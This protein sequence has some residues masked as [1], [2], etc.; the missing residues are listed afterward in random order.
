MSKILSS[1][2]NFAFHFIIFIEVNYIL[3]KFFV[4][5][6]LLF[7]VSEASAIPS[8]YDLRDYGRI[9]SVKHQGIPGPCWA[10]AA[11][12][13]CES[14]YLTQNLNTDGKIPDL[15]EM[16][17]AF[18][19]YKNPKTETTFTSPK[20]GTLSLEGNTFMPV[21][22][23]SRLAGPVDDK[24]LRYST[25]LSYSEIKNLAKKLPESF[26][27]SMRLRDAY[28]LSGIN[29]PNE[30]DRKN[31]I[32]NHGAIAVTMY[33]DPNKYRTKGKYYTY[34]NNEHGKETNHLVTIAGWDDNFSRENFEPKPS[35][36]GAWLIKNS[37]GTSRGTNDGYFWLSYDQ[38]TY[39]GTAFIV[40]KYNSRLKHY[41]YDDL[42]W[43]GQVNSSWAANVFK[44]SGNKEKLIETAFYTTQNNLDYEIYVYDLGF[45]FPKSPTE[46]K[47][48]STEKGNLKY[49][50]YH[51]IKLK[52]EIQIS[53][54][55]YFSVVVKL[56]NKKFAVEKRVKNYS[57]NAVINERESYF[58]NDG[59]NWT[60]GIE[61][62]SNVCIKAF[63]KK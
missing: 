52:D 9:T 6:I 54:E 2:F 15:S 63:T 16:H 3:K 22:L 36:N 56:S 4:I 12:A 43:C 38:H 31:L 7:C 34:Y 58:S 18:F 19:C 51:T 24:L 33:S 59:K 21:A 53:Y 25:N 60:D 32:I 17:T 27:R 62:K 44:I 28:F 45:D 30:N 40:E 8:S 49:T 5:L 42:G 13:A 14:N 29:A 55:K 35:R 48:I 61:L 47:L 11:M 26:K 23:M 46:G 10:F 39:G 50:G 37:W 41:G 1:I 20:S 57:E